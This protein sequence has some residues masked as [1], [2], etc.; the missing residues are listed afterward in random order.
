MRSSG[1]KLVWEHV[2]FRGPWRCLRKDDKSAV[3]QV[4]L[5]LREEM[6]VT[7]ICLGA[8]SG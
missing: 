8:P 2:E 6:R 1:Y 4:D 3:E 7:N 5:G